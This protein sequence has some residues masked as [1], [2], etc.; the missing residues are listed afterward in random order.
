MAKRILGMIL[1]GGQG[2][3]LAPLTARRSKPAVQCR[4]SGQMAQSLRLARYL[5]VVPSWTVPEVFSSLPP[6][7]I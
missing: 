4:L 7:Q 3:R 6:G 2:T 1:A 5:I